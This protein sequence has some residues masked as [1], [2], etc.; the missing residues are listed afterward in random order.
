MKITF[1]FKTGGDDG[2]GNAIFDSLC[3][4]CGLVGTTRRGSSSR[5]NHHFF[6]RLGESKLSVGRRGSTWC[7]GRF[8]GRGQGVALRQPPLCLRQHGTGQPRCG[9]NRQGHC[10]NRAAGVCCRNGIG[11]QLQ[12]KS[13]AACSK[14]RCAD[15]PGVVRIGLLIGQ[16]DLHNP[17]HCAWSHGGS[18]CVILRIVLD[19]RSSAANHLCQCGNPATGDGAVGAI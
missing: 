6:R 16:V 9:V 3:R 8:A 2:D 11:S 15:R 10:A 13:K 19:R 18:A 1:I 12:L 5:R 14:R 4:G 17:F 7:T